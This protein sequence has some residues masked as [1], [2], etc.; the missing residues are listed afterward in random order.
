MDAGGAQ[1]AIDLGRNAYNVPDYFG[2]LRFTYYRT[3]TESHNT[4]LL[5]RSDQDTMAEAPIV[6]HRFKPELAFTRV[7][8]SAAYP[9]K[10]KR[11]TAAWPCISARIVTP[12]PEPSDD[13][14]SISSRNCI[15]H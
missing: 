12:P 2:K 10:T 15:Q 9:G 1:W 6:E 3:R 7:D 13:H 4:I 14:R 11:L 8:L 5:D